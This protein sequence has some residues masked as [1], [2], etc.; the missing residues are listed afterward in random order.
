MK[1]DIAGQFMEVFSS[2][3]IALL[4]NALSNLPDTPNASDF[5]AYTNGFQKKDLIYLFIKK[6]IIEKLE[7]LFGRPIDLLHG[8]LLKEKK[9]WQIH[10]DYLKGDANPDLAILIPLNV[11]LVN[12]C[13]VIFNELATDSFETYKL[14]NK[15]LLNNATTMHNDLMS[16]ELIENLEY[17]SLLNSYHWIPGSVIY[18]DRKLLHASDNFLQNGITEKTALVLFTTF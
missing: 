8:M 3:E 11:T 6:R 14:K 2:S 12:T 15:K 4:L 7:Q 16:H 9:P 1:H 17:V 10:T 13:T 18:W 5:H